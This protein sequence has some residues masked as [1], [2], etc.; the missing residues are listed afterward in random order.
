LTDTE[1]EFLFCF[2]INF[3]Y[4]GILY[5]FNSICHAFS[6]LMN[7]LISFPLNT[8]FSFKSSVCTDLLNLILLL[9]SNQLIAGSSGL[10]NPRNYPVF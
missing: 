7:K 3:I 5:E 9:S 6:L 8:I 2:D 1:D 4:Q 10:A